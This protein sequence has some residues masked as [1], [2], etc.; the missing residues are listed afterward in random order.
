MKKTMLIGLGLLAAGM[1][2]ARE[3]DSHR[4]NSN[5]GNNGSAKAADCSPSTALTELALNNIRALLETGGNMW[6]N[7][8]EG[9][10][11]YEVPKT[12]DRSG[13]NSLFAGALWMG[14]V[15]PDNQL[16]LAAVRFRQD[17]NDFWPGP[18]TNTGD[19][20]ITPEECEAYD[21]TWRTFRS[22]AALHEAYFN[23]LADPDC[24]ESEEYEGYV[25]PP[26]FFDWPAQGDLDLN[27]DFYLA[28][29]TDYN[30]DGLYEPT[31]GDYPGYDLD[32]V[33]DC[34]NRFREDPVPLF[35]D[36]NIWW[37]FN[38]KGNVHTETGADPIGMEIRAQA[39]AFSTNDEVNNMTF[40]NYVL[41]NQGTQTLT[42]TYFGQWVDV[43]LGGA[44]DDYV[45]CDVERGLGYGYNG[46]D[47]DEDTGNSVGYGVQPPAV[48]VDFFEGPFADEDEVDNPLTNNVLNALD[49][50]GIVYK[51]IGIGYGDG[52]VDNERFGMRAFLYHNNTGQGANPATTDPDNAIEHYNFLRAIWK[53]NSPMLFGG[54]GHTSSSNADPNTPTL[55]MF[56]GDSDPLHWGTFGV[57]AGFE[58]TE[59][60]EG[61]APDDRRFIQ[62]AGPFTLDPGEYNNIT[63]GVVWARATA[64]GPFASVQAVRTADD[65]AQALFDNCFRILDGP[66][67]PDLTFQELDR[68]LILYITNPESSNNFNELYEEL[69][70]TIPEEVTL[71]DSTVIF[72]DRFYR[73]QGYQIYQLKNADVSV[74]DLGDINLARPLFQV[75][76]DDGIAQIVNYINDPQIGLP[77]PTEMVDGADEG[78]A[79]SFKITE[80]LFATG[81]NPLLVNHKTYYYMAIAYGYNEWAQYNPSTLSGQPFPYKAGR[82]AATGSIRAYTAVPHIPTP[83]NGGTV[84]NAE[85]GDG[86]QVTRLEGQGNGS[87]VVDLTD[88]TLESIVDDPNWKKDEITYTVGMGPVDV[89]VIDPL[90]LPNDEFELWFQDSITDGDL[91]D[92]YW[93]LVRLGTQDTVW[94]DRSIAIGTEQIITEWG[95]S[96]NLGQH[97][98]TEST[99]YTEPLESVIEFEDP[100]AEWLGGVPDQEG[101]NIFNWIRAGTTVTEDSDLPETIWNDYV[102]KDDDE[103]YEGLLGGT[104]SV[105][106]LVGDTAFQPG[107][108]RVA[109]T[110]NLTRISYTSSVAVVITKDKSRWTRCPVLEMQLNPN[111]ARYD[112]DVF[113]SGAAKLEMRAMRS[114]DKEGRNSTH[115][116]YNAADGDL[117]S[118]TGM[119]W[120]PGYVVNLETGERLN[121]AFGEDSWL[122][123][124]NGNDMVW[125]PSNRLTTD[126]GAPLLGG[127]HWIFVF[128]NDRMLTGSDSRMPQYDQGQYA[129]DFLSGSSSDI[130]KVFRSTHWIGSSLV[131][132]EREL[133]ETDVK[134]RLN[135]AK[136]YE[137]FKEPYAGYTPSIDASRNDGLPLYRFDTEG[138]ET[139][140]NQVTV[141]EDALDLINVVPNPYLA[142]SAYERNRIDTRVKFTNLPQVC[143]ISIYNSSG[144]LVRQYKKDDP[145]TSL[146]WDLKNSTNVPI[147]GGTYICH[148][149]VPGVG[150]TIVKWFGALRPVDLDNL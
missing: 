91:D 27:Q 23:C 21:R 58:W 64:G 105:W 52:V 113:S 71:P 2:Q 8:A 95:I 124:E 81:S 80:D 29:F 4:S 112:D 107:D 51:G 128:R 98:Y 123:G 7:R 42:D 20:S 115:P 76:L 13:A 94:A 109:N 136:P 121:M 40:Y 46:D 82:K 93:F 37:V 57:D 45:G 35:G 41:I 11:A 26:V 135:V 68:E 28:P 25:I 33:V 47:N 88:E 67:A 83:E 122:A 146:D 147:A 61:N 44:D 12:V 22:D 119:G 55:Y 79:H 86:L 127:Q 36:E 137:E 118:N 74:A 85:Y 63:V 24:N 150:E 143:T 39:F 32:G 141:A 138:F 84:T 139:Y 90:N 38:D 144:T 30:Q 142:Y 73:F 34:K 134:I 132:P 19:A 131:L 56:P 145:T 53:D 72:P 133:M 99:R 111:L 3:Y 130:T 75:D 31:D 6:Q 66:D 97:Y 9:T 103:L 101:F 140:T 69:D 78:I 102:G 48:G 110:I 149:D 54:T 17:G 14:G 92:A 15:S 65:K 125:N 117:V 70:P 100:S 5:R 104:W 43:D 108:P 77:V 60:G 126:L 96:V 148:I 114:V 59:E 49:S 1:I 120:F 106:P 62:S 16:K 18:L 129:H 87:L 10:A 116:N 89:K 50:N